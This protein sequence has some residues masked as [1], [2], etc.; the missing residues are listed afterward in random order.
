M[1]NSVLFTN[2]FIV[3]TN[4]IPVVLA[5]DWQM[6]VSLFFNG[7]AYGFPCALALAVYWAVRR[8]VRPPRFPSDE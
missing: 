2:V 6:Q 1:T 4:P 3:N 7:F 5:M 8:A